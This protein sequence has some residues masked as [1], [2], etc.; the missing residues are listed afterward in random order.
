MVVSKI[1]V[2]EE[3]A[4]IIYEHE[5]KRIFRKFTYMRYHSFLMYFSVLKRLG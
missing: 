2:T 1:D 3:Q 4:E 5:I